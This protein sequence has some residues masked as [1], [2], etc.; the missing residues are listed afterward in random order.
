MCVDIRKYTRV[1]IRK[2]RQYLQHKALFTNEIVWGTSP[3]TAWYTRNIEAARAIALKAGG[4]AMLF[5]PV[6][7]K[8]KVL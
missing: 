2:N 7:G 8:T 1:I 6:I 3:Y 5:N 4:T